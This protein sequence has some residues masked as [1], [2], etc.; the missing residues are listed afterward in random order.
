VLALDGAQ[1][2]LDQ[3]AVRCRDMPWIEFRR[4]MVPAAFP[5]GMFDLILLSEVL[6]FLDADDVSRTASLAQDHLA[7]GGL[8]VLVNWTGETDTPTTGEQACA[9]FQAAAQRLGV[10]GNMCVATYRI[11]VLAAPESKEGLVF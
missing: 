2:A 1:A 4:A 11:D 3:A 10:V 5:D 7:P 6:Y 9:L 8:V